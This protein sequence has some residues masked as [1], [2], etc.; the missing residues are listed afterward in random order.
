L[1]RDRQPL[2]VFDESAAGWDETLSNPSY[3]MAMRIYTRLRLAGGWYFFTVNLAV[4]RGND[5][6]VR[7]LADL[8]DAFR[9]TRH[10][11]PFSLEAIVILP[12]HH[13]PVNHGCVDVGRRRACAFPSLDAILFP[14]C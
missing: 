5:L 13:N 6:L 4:R 7:Y 9:H 2:I 10:D 14:S 8:R 12:E 1:S 3:I 11:H